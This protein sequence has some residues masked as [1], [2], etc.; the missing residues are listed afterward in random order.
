MLIDK[1]LRVTISLNRKSWKLQW[2]YQFQKCELQSKDIKQI[3]QY[4]WLIVEF[5]NVWRVY[6]F[7][8]TITN[9]FR[10]T[11]KKSHCNRS[12]N[13]CFALIELKFSKINF[14][15]K[16]IQKK[17]SITKKT[18]N[19]NDENDRKKKTKI[20]TTTTIAIAIIIVR[21]TTTE[22]IFDEKNIFVIAIAIFHERKTTHKTNSCI[23]NFE[24]IK[25]RFA[26]VRTTNCQL[27]KTKLI[28][29]T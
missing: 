27:T 22:R 29:Q 15:T 13:I 19:E 3:A 4:F 16:K 21:T 12:Y 10:K 5:T 24:C 6:Q 2:V 18:N 11:H 1:E 25:K 26:I 9:L 14:Y 17:H 8:H 28:K 23:C 7:V 20:T